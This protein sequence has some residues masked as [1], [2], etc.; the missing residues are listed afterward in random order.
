MENPKEPTVRDIRIVASEELWSSFE[1]WM[2]RQSCTS[3]AEGFRIA[4]R[5]VT[6]FGQKKGDETS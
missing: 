2:R 5:S 3:L 4:M 1:Q 6:N